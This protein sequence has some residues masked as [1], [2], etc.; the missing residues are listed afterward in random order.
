MN[1]FQ[2]GSQRTKIVE[3]CNYYK[4]KYLQQVVNNNCLDDTL[5]TEFRLYETVSMIH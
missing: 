4:S 1:E 5:K 2:S 3:W